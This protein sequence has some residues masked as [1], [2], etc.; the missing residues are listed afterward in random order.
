MDQRRLKS[1]A[2]FADLSGRDRRRVARWAEEWEIDRGEELVRQGEEA[3]EF[4]V[5]TH[6]LAEV[7][8]DGKPLTDL[9]PGQF[10]GE[11]AL[12][13]EGGRRNASVIAKSKIQVVSMSRE[14]FHEM[15][16]ELPNV[17][18]RI[19]DVIHQRAE[20]LASRISPA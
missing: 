5:I 18:E 3:N 9:L 15:T 12:L 8:V 19:R 6:G 13:L 16:R 10:F 7:L 1:V 2:L 17:A 4:Y 20:E 14:G 11:M